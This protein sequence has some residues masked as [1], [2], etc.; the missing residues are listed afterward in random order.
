MRNDTVE[1]PAYAL[2]ASMSIELTPSQL[3]R[4]G[5]LEAKNVRGLWSVE[6]V[7]HFHDGVQVSISS[8]LDDGFSPWDEDWT[9]TVFVWFDY[10]E[11]VRVVLAW[12]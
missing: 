7:D 3:D 5:L 9:D 4:F 6:A 10:D 2:D 12:A 8:R 11:L 1:V